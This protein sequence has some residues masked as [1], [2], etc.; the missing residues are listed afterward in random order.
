ME[1][2]KLRIA[3]SDPEQKSAG[4][5]EYAVDV[6][7]KTTV[8]DCLDRIQR[9]T[10]PTLAFRYACRAGMCGSCA[11]LVNGKERWTCRTL[12]GKLGVSELRIEPLRHL[13]VI[14]DL[15]VDFAPLWQ[16]YRKVKPAF[17]GGGKQRRPSVGVEDNIQ[18]ISCGACYSSC[19]F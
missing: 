2:I 8:L 6:L 7:E 1:S 4:W 14:R 15:A 16:K 18:C 11:M 3:R 13:P 19:T 12:V 10:D 5:S 9:T 17:E